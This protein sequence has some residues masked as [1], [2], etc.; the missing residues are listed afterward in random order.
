MSLKVTITDY[1]V[2]NLY[3]IRRSLEMCGAEV[4]VI[5]DMSKL[6]DA[7]CIVFPGVGAFNKSMERL[8]PYR[9]MIRE[10]VSSGVP[11]LGICIG[12]QI[13]FE[14]SDEGTSPVWAS[15]MEGSR[16]S[17]AGWSPTWAGTRS[18]AVMP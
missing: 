5:T 4:E 1:G 12:M 9:D 11:T 15:M 8:L 16:S 2:G 10:R 13:M 6:E 7:E 3:S 17:P 14:G 18:R